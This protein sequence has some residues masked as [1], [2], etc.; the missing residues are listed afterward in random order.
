MA[1]IHKNIKRKKA[2]KV[3]L[4]VYMLVSCGL[5]SQGRM[6]VQ[7]TVCTCVYSTTD[8]GGIVSTICDALGIKDTTVLYDLYRAPLVR[9]D[10]HGSIVFAS[11]RMSRQLSHLSNN[12]DARCTCSRR[13]ARNTRARHRQSQQ[14]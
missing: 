9:E 2:A 4:T 1:R 8:K 10:S 3:N 6:A 5:A 7:E 11:C 12:G 13:T 14:Q